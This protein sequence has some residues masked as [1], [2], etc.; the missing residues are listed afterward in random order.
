MAKLLTLLLPAVLTVSC[1]QSGNGLSKEESYFRIESGQTV[2]SVSEKGATQNYVVK[3]NGQWDI[4]RKSGETWAE[5]KPGSG[6]NDGSFRIKVEENRTGKNRSMRFSFLLN[7]EEL[8]ESVAVSQEGKELIYDERDNQDITV[9]RAGIPA[10]SETNLTYRRNGSSILQA[11]LKEP[12]V[13]AVAE[14]PEGWGYFQFPNIN[15]SSNVLVA[16]WAMAPDSESSYG[17]GSGGFKLSEDNG[18]TWYVSETRPLVGGLMLPGGSRI[19]VNTPVALDVKTLQ[20]PAPLATVKEAYGRTFSFYRM[21]DLPYELQGVYIN[22]YDPAGKYSRIHSTLDDQNVVRYASGELFPIVWWGDMKL[23]PDNSIV[24]GIYPAFYE[25]EYGGV[26]ASGVSFY[27]SSNNGMTWK[28]KGK[29]PYTPDLATDPNGN[30]RLAFGY[31]EPAFEILQDGTYLCVLRT[32]DGYGN[33]PMYISRSTDQGTTWSNPVTF[34]PSGVLPRLLQLDNG[35]L[36]LASGRPGVQLRFSTDGKGEKWTDPFEM[37]PFEDQ[38]DQVSCGY[39]SLLVAG[40][41]SFLLIYSDF[42]YLN[43][44]NEVRKAIKIREVKVTPK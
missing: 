32:T 25:N 39:P 19:S 17:K 33:S 34:T 13:V 11:E 44:N 16:S 21:N 24:I 27:R 30:R 31:T 26:N 6:G 38:S 3:S 4:I 14:R 15:R 8:S 22:Y 40:P 43:Q 20:L 12:V 10:Y 1:S 5:A 28:I 29:I 18:K 9:I 37:L 41:D 7:G 23:L 42:K 35:V 2:W 36:V